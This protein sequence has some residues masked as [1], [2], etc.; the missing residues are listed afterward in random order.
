VEIGIS[1]ELATLF[2]TAARAAQRFFDFF[3]ANTRIKHTRRA[4]YNA[5]CK[6][7]DFCAEGGG[8]IWNM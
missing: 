6:F 7:S 3:T 4:H 1:H 2:L 5:A 8:T